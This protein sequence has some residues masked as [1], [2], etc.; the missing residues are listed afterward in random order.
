MENNISKIL[1]AMN[2]KPATTEEK[3]KD[4]QLVKFQMIFNTEPAKEIKLMSSNQI[5]KI[6]YYGLQGISLDNALKLEDYI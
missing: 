3:N 6:N 1:K 4:E 5:E 2:F